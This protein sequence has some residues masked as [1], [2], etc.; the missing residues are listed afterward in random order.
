MFGCRECNACQGTANRKTDTIKVTFSLPAD[1]CDKE[2]SDPDEGGAEVELRRIRRVAEMEMRRQQEIER[3]KRE[4]EELKQREQERLLWLEK[5]RL[6]VQWQRLEEGQRELEEGRRKAED[7]RKQEQVDRFLS[8]AGFTGINDKKKKKGS[9]LSTGFTYALHAAVRANDPQAV[10]LL[11]W[12]GAD[13]TLSDSAKLTPLQLAQKLDKKG[14]H[15]QVV[16]AL[17]S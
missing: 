11:L 1:A 4:R 13:R 14:S 8:N 6:R 16:D 5:E 9:L 7:A 2:N 12:R 17:S 15:L 3:L 10:G